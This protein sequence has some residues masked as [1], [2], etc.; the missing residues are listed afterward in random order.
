MLKEL[1]ERYKCLLREMFLYGI[2]GLFSAFMDTFSFALISK[3]GMSVLI[4]NFISVNIGITISFFL[5]TFLNFKKSTKLIWRAAKF[6]GVGYI[7]LALS[8][9]IMWLGVIVMDQQHMAVKVISVVAAA[10]LQ[11]LFNKFF[12]FKN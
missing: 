9:F 1:F 10:A 7:G 12:T 8:T 4:A 5:N 2:F 11:Y 6:F 3:T